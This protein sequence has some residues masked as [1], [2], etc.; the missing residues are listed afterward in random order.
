MISRLRAE[1]GFSLVEVL[2]AALVLVLALTAL[3]AVFIN[4]QNQSS[5]QLEESQMINAADQQIEQLRAQ[6]NAGK[7]NALGVSANPT[8][9]TQLAGT[10]ES[11]Y[12]DPDSFAFTSGTTECYDINNN[13]DHVS[14]SAFASE[15]PLDFTQWSDCSSYGEPVEV[16]GTSALVVEGTVSSGGSL[17]S[18]VATQACPT[19]GSS[20][21]DS[22]CYLNFGGTYMNVYTFVTD[23]YVGCSTVT[24]SGVACP[25]NTA[26][27]VQASGCTFPTATVG[28][29]ASA[30]GSTPCADAR[31]VTVAVYPAHAH[32]QLARITPVY[33][34]SLFTNPVP[35]T[36]QQSSIGLTLE[37][38]L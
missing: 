8:V 32:Q 7:F 30:P 9:A 2:V 34:S 12:K 38:T 29:G 37:A 35:T 20:T 5:A 24:A 27:T 3:A 19:S 28:V 4:N 25:T 23:T 15:T 22:P 18:G 11:T 36:T 16:L 1:E 6:V 26:G 17:P 14:S 21:I 10:V 33:I 13:Y 31:R